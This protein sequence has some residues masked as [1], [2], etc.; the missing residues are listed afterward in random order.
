MTDRNG[1]PRGAR[2]PRDDSV[3]GVSDG[4]E[5]GVV[6]EAVCRGSYSRS[7]RPRGA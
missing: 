7:I 1:G 6:D 2:T 4:V 5:S 3:S